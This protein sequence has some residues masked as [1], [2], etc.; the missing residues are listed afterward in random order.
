LSGATYLTKGCYSDWNLSSK[1]S[2]SFPFPDST[3]DNVGIDQI[4]N[5]AVPNLIFG[6]PGINAATKGWFLNGLEL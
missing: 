2:I 1:V 6:R 4:T 5:K 3:L